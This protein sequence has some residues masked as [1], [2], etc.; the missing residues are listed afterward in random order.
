MP[1]TELEVFVVAHVEP[2]LVICKWVFYNTCNSIED[3]TLRCV[4]CVMIA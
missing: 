2:R 4:A 3:R 1:A